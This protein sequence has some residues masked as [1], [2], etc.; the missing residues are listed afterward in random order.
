MTPSAASPSLHRPIAIHD[1]QSR[2]SVTTAF[3]EPIVF[4]Y[5]FILWLLGQLLSFCAAFR[6]R[7][8]PLIDYRG[9]SGHRLGIG[10]YILF[11]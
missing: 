3:I 9:T 10:R 7:F 8:P 11:V 1:R 4:Y 5:L 2:Q 6:P